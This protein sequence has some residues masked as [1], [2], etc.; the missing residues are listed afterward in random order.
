MEG[1]SLCAIRRALGLS[2]VLWSLADIEEYVIDIGRDLEASS[3]HV[4][5]SVNKA[6]DLL[7]KEG[8]HCQEPKTCS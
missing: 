2:K 8:V 5:R 3:F 4:K 7:A 1:D 6:T